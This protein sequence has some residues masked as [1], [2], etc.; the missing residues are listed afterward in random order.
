MAKSPHYAGGL[1]GRQAEQ[2][3]YGLLVDEEEAWREGLRTA[4]EIASYFG[5]PEGMIRV[6]GRLL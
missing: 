5:V 1:L 3:A 4:Q 2:F 6:Q